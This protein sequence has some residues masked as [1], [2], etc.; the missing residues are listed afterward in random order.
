MS[1]LHRPDDAARR[2]SAEQREE[3]VRLILS[4]R[5]LGEPRRA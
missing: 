2:L 1:E 3:L 4:W 5:L